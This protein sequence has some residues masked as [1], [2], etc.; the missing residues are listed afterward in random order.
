MNEHEQLRMKIAKALHP[1]AELRQCRDQTSYDSTEE[2]TEVQTRGIT[3]TDPKLREL[4]ES[5]LYLWPC[6]KR[7]DIW[8][9]VS[10]WLNDISAAWELLEECGH[11]VEIYK[12]F[13]NDE[14]HVIVTI[15][16]GNNRYAE[17]AATAPEA[18]CK[19]W[20]AWKEAQS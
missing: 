3:A 16:D 10:D 12:S 6:Y 4:L 15:I 11:G 9:P 18:I 5:T 13:I 20:L 7:N 17:S 14:R 19:A 1:E 8:T 2:I